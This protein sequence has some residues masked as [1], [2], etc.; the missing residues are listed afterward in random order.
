MEDLVDFC[1]EKFKGCAPKITHEMVSLYQSD[2]IDCLLPEDKLP[3]ECRLSEKGDQNYFVD[4]A[5]QLDFHIDTEFDTP[6][7]RSDYKQQMK[8]AFKKGIDN[9]VM[10]STWV[11]ETSSR[12]HLLFSMTTS[13]TDSTGR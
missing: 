2:F 7:I 4:G 10:R 5:T 1:F 8:N 11:N 12:S 6:D 13:W 3:I 9:R